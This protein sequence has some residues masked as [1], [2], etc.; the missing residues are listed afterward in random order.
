MR[1]SVKIEEEDEQA[2]FLSSFFYR[3]KIVRLLFWEVKHDRV[4][5]LPAMVTAFSNISFPLHP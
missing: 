4:V 3:K 1:I 2:A 5:A